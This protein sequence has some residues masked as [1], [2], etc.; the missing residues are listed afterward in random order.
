MKYLFFLPFTS[1]W[2]SNVWWCL[3]DV[4]SFLVISFEAASSF[5]NVLDSDVGSVES[6]WIQHSEYIIE[7]RGWFSMF[8]IVSIIFIPH[9]HIRHPPWPQQHHFSSRLGPPAA[10]KGNQSAS[11]NAT[12]VG[13]Q[14]AT[15]TPGNQTWQL[16]LRH[17]VRLFSQLQTLEDFLAMFDRGY[18]TLMVAKN[19]SMGPSLLSWRKR[20]C[21]RTNSFL[22]RGQVKLWSSREGHWRWKSTQIPSSDMIC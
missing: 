11:P 17:L 4:P 14:K 15:F 13:I 20:G 5:P 22:W 19:P 16:K 6:A 21:P 8:S 10:S 9:C 3:Q 1:H 7:N 12:N 2:W 18:V